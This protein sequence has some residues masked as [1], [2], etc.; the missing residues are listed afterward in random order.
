[1]EGSPS[2]SSVGCLAFESL[3]YLQNNP[4]R[5][6]SQ[7]RP[8]PQLSFFPSSSSSVSSNHH[9]RKSSSILRHVRRPTTTTTTRLWSSPSNDGTKKK[10]GTSTDAGEWK[11]IVSALTIYKAAYGNLQVPQ[12]FVVPNLQPWPKS[13]W[14]MRLG[15]VVQAIRT[16]GKYIANQPARQA[17]LQQAGFVWQ[18]SSTAS[19]SKKKKKAASTTKTVVASVKA[20]KKKAAKTVTVK[21]TTATSKRA[22]EVKQAASSMGVAAS[23]QQTM[24]EDAEN[25]GD[26]LTRRV[27]RIYTALSNYAELYN[28]R[29][30]VPLDFVV[31]S[32]SPEWPTTVQGLPLGQEMDALLTNGAELL[33]Q[34]PPEWRRK[35]IALLQA[36]TTETSSTS[37]TP[38]M[39]ETP[40]PT[41]ISSESLLN[42]D[43]IQAAEGTKSTP[44][45]ETVIPS[46][47]PSVMM[48]DDGGVPSANDVRFEKVYRAL[49]TYKQVYGD[50]LVPQPFI[51][52]E[53]WT[54]QPDLWGFRLGARVNAIRSQGTFVNKHPERRQLLDDLGFVWNPPRTEQ[55][56]AGRPSGSTNKSTL[57][58][59]MLD[60][61]SPQD[62]M[63]MKMAGSADDA[64]FG[65]LGGEDDDEDDELSSL[66][67]KSFDFLEKDGTGARSS[68]Q[69]ALSSINKDRQAPITWG[70]EGGGDLQELARLQQKQMEQ[71]QNLDEGT[72]APPRTL[73]ESL[74]EARVRAQEVGII[75]EGKGRVIK[76]KR[77]K[78]VPWFN[79]DF[80]DDFVFDDVL[81]ALTLYQ[82]FY[83]NF[84]NLTM[85]F[86]FVIPPPS[87]SLRTGFLDEYGMD[88]D[89][90]FLRSGLASPASA[91]DP[92]ASARAAQAIAQFEEAGEFDQSQDLIA[93]EIQRLQQN[94]DPSGTR[95]DPSELSDLDSDLESSS[96]LVT[97][98]ASMTESS[99]RPEKHE[100]PEHLAG[101]QLGHIARR[102]QD[103]SLEI[104]HLEERKAKLDALGF[105]WGDERYFIDVPFEKAMCAMYAYYLVRGDMFV[106]ENFV[107]PDEDPWPKALAGYEIGQAVKRIRELQNFLEAYHPE[108]VSLLRMI[109]FVWFPTLAL[110]L[111]PDDEIE[112]DNEMLRLTGMG[113]PD[114]A[115]RDIPLA[116]HEQIL[117]DG[118]FYDT[119]GDPKL[120]WREWHN[121]DYVK[122]YWYEQGRRDNAHVLREMGYPRMADEHEA[123]YGPGLLTQLEWT[124]A[125]LRDSEKTAI[126]AKTYEER[127]ELIQKLNF[128]RQEMKDCTDIYMDD[129]TA[130]LEELD[131]KIMEI[132]KES[133][134]QFDDDEDDDEN[135]SNQE[136]TDDEDTSE[137]EE[138]EDDDLMIVE[139]DFDV[140]GELGLGSLR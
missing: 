18:T 137:D 75:E 25:D 17:W 128:F 40:E 22:V 42:Q 20:K 4:V 91:F 56:R 79:D 101:M 90:T 115:I 116:I 114:Y 63:R 34:S 43:P 68:T 100:W 132:M 80:G 62:A 64:M 16:T 74:S 133:N 15:L 76:G 118:P 93:A 35:F 139:E 71:R 122:D 24:K 102:I 41:D 59:Q 73:A 49:S 46:S 14:G 38:S 85:N 6:Q 103:G 70:F 27:S 39:A 140:D 136:Q 19:K 31:P 53:S 95:L 58:D 78:E 7:Q 112:M 44:K 66:F 61:Y 87:M 13:A 96:N 55:R 127:K 135:E 11:A 117:A 92:D 77:E 120:W 86:D 84:A 54:D 130:I 8:L 98:M 129:R 32:T 29:T 94:P 48:T 81:E 51:V 108:K 89:D 10:A 121:W 30:T 67:D 97:T 113:H 111:D 99:S 106:Y 9:H 1:M 47:F 126:K 5:R 131:E 28:G 33:L 125:P 107:M 60:P 50:L 104:R 3:P 105:D 123:K 65:G 26:A 124:L 83:G 69:G 36:P 134:M 21:G 2:G 12:R 109:D 110:P 138:D 82:S 57:S 119:G 23:D 45:E 37:S 88:G 72:Y 52:P